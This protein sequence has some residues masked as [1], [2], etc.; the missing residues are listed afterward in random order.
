MP[1]LTSCARSSRAYSPGTYCARFSTPYAAELLAV[2][3]GYH[4]LLQ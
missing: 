3:A 1:N 2:C 4:V